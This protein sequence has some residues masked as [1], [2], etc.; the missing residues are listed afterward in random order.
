MPAQILLQPVEAFPDVFQGI[1]VGK[2]QKSL[3]AAAKID[4]GGNAHFGL[5]GNAE[6]FLIRIFA[7]LARVGKNV[8][9]AGGLNMNDK[10]HFL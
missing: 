10:S 4:A 7:E 8:K 2:A 1:G 3:A 9:S 6:S 5:L